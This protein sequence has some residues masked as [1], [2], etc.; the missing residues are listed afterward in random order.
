ML[1]M[2]FLLFSLGEIDQSKALSMVK[3]LSPEQLADMMRRDEI[4]NLLNVNT[5]EFADEAYRYWDSIPIRLPMEKAAINRISSDYGDRIHPILGFKRHHDGLDLAGN[6]GADI[7][8]T[9]DGIVTTARRSRN[10]YGNMIIVEHSNGYKTRYAHLD[11]IMIKKGEFVKAG[12]KIGTLGTSGLST[13]PHLHYEVIKDNEPIDPM[14]FSYKD[15]GDRSEESYY[16]TVV[17]LTEHENKT[18]Y[19][20]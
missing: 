12:D 15:K 2:L 14:F 17:A 13:G 16:K 1:A 8:S 19:H 6:L 4:R 20:I 7:Y 11:D 10:G 18:M 9:A 3:E 5:E